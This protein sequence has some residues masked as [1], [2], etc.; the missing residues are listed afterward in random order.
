MSI[1]ESAVEQIRQRR[2]VSKVLFHCS[3]PVDKH[4]SMKN[5]N[6]IRHA[7]ARRFIGKPQVV[8]NAKAR[9]ALLIRQEWA[10]LNQAPIDRP[11]WCI[12]HFFF[13][14]F[15]VKPKRKSDPPRMSMTLGDQSNIYQMVEDSLQ[16]AG[17]L[18]NDAWICSHDLS[19]R[20]PSANGYDYLE[21]F[22]IDYPHGTT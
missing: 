16:E 5:K 4:W 21:I 13:K 15:Y 10:R 11:V 8:V 3:F 17:V 6:K 1:I 18:T 9:M 19:R 20:L 14:D 12:F 2:E 7:G 22:V